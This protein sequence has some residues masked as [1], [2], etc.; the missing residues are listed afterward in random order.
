MT[1]FRGPLNPLKLSSGSKKLPL[2]L[3]QVGKGGISKEFRILQKGLKL[4]VE[5]NERS[6]VIGYFIFK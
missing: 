6:R 3:E 2:E 4:H 5:T 1:E